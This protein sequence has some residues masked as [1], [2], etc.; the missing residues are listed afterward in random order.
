MA[1][2]PLITEINVLAEAQQKMVNEQEKE[3]GAAEQDR[4]ERMETLNKQLANSEHNSKEN[5]RIR[6][7]I[8][9]AN[10]TAR[11]Q[12][13]ISTE[14]SRSTASALGISGGDEEVALAVE[15]LNEQ[16]KAI[17]GISAADLKANKELKV[18]IENDTK[19]LEAEGAEIKAAGADP[20]KNEDK[21]FFSLDNVS[22]IGYYY[23]YGSERL[24]ESSNLFSEIKKAIKE[25]MTDDVRVMYGVYETNYEQDYVY[26]VKHTSVIQEQ[27]GGSGDSLTSP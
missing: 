19:V 14:I 8:V 18:A 1:D 24:E 15:A 11:E 17:L 3:A 4:S 23:A 9:M 10:K 26:C 5:I 27:S 16:T 13:S 12:K 20:E 25:K 6:K 2:D 7:E 22:D 21:V